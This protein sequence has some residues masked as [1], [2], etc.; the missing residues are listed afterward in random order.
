VSKHEASSRTA[1]I[2]ARE[3]IVAQLDDI[4][5]AKQ[6]G[7][8]YAPDFRSAAAELEEELRQIDTLLDDGREASEPDEDRRLPAQ[9]WGAVRK[10]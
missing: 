3:A 1:L 6:S 10:D 8:Y 9:S 7:Y 5:A 2:E 4:E